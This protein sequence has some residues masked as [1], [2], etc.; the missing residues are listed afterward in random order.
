VPSQKYIW[1][2]DSL[3]GIAILA[4]LAF[5]LGEH[6]KVGWFKWGCYGVDLFFVLSG[7][8][9]TGIL[10]RNRDSDG[11]FRNFYARRVLRIWPVYFAFL[12]LMMIVLPLALPGTMQKSVESLRPLWPFPLFLQ[13][14]F[15]HH[16]IVGPVGVTWSLCI[17]EQFYVLW[18]LLVFLL[19][20]RW[21]KYLAVGA[22]FSQPL[23][24]LAFEY[25]NLSAI[26]YTFSL[27]RLDGLAIGSIMAILAFEG[28]TIASQR[29]VIAGVFLTAT[30]AI[31][32]P[33]LYSGLAL[34][35]AGI[36]SASMRSGQVPR[37]G[38]LEFIGK[39]SYGL[40][41]WHLIAFDFFETP[42]VY[43]GLH[44]NAFGYSLASVA[45]A[46]FIAWASF[47]LFESPILT[48]KRHFNE[49]R[50]VSSPSVPP[51]QVT[52]FESPHPELRHN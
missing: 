7:F 51:L 38:P 52:A 27:T 28:E 48:L 50:N 18:P 6:L 49:R 19:P 11:F 1:Q 3:R 13:N 4:V 41:L 34:L 40:Y 46:I 12:A 5:H 31:F 42:T 22:F 23:F 26:E 10:L 17:E 21:L 44:L 36:S 15:V 32:H 16:H 30:G 45:L 47:R 29:W 25:H 24:R 33:L 8:L 43:R 9:V 2:F 37:F 35:F 20:T 39:I 14:L